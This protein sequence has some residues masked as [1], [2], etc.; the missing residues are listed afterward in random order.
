M[1]R[2]LFGIV[3]GLL[4]GAVLLEAQALSPGVLQLLQRD[5]TWTGTQ[6]FNASVGDGGIELTD[7]APTT[8]SMRLYRVGSTLYFNGSIVA[9][10]APGAAVPHNL[11]S[12]D[13]PD[14]SAQSPVR[15]DLVVATAAPNWERFAIGG[16]GSMLRSNGGDP[17]WSTDAS[18]LTQLNASQLSAG[19]VPLARL[20]GITNTQIA[21]AAAIAWT[22]L[23]TTG[24]S[25]ADLVTR[26]AA[27]LS[28]GTLADARLGATVSLLGQTI[29][30]AEIT[31]GTIVFADWGSNACGA[32]Q[33]AQYNGA[34]WVCAADA[35]TGTVTSVA[36][37]VPAIFSLAGSPVTTTG[38]FALTLATEV[39]NTV[40]AGPTTGAAVAPTFRALVDDD[41][42]DT[43]TVAGTGNVTWAS[44]N[45]S[46]STLADLNTRLISDTTGTLAATRGGTGVITVA[47]GQYLR[48]SGLDTWAT[49]AILAADLPATALTTTSV[50]SLTNKTIDAEAAGNIITLPV[51][52]YLKAA[53]CNN[54]TA[55]TDWSFETT[56]PAVPTCVTGTNTQRGVLGFT[57]AGTILKAHTELR[58]AGDWDVGVVDAEF[59]WHTTAV[60][61]AVVWQLETTCV[62]AG[63]TGDPAFNTAQVVVS[64]AQ[65][66]TLFY[67]EAAM[68]GVDMTGCAAGEHLYLRV[69]RDPAHVS[70]TLAATASLVG[71][72][73]TYRRAM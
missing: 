36:M 24:S 59:T 23:D 45:Q 12:A 35:G 49:S 62:A 63:E 19:S 41:I 46:A 10:I 29:E 73:L 44:I 20:S 69:S 71:L 27:D 30:S 21:G 3:A 70:D 40:W 38:T 5:N 4:L 13:H 34:A 16:V 37:T 53:T 39:A 67:Q 33:V 31:N 50:S 58:L 56:L 28:S 55:D 68:A 54:A 52:E 48:A 8:T 11:L 42:L 2:L 7:G 57:D 15:G 51:V 17:V 1:R 25:L 61:G 43:L 66:T 65:G 64:N 6:T 18:S 9:A 22:K 60:S 26:S 72:E 32:G 14:T 47:A